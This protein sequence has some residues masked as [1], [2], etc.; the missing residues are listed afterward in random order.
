MQA[1][2]LFRGSGIGKQLFITTM[3]KGYE[4]GCKVALFFVLQWN[5]A[6]NFYKKLGAINVSEKDNFHIFEL[7]SD[8]F[9]KLCF[10]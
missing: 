6:V 7:E 9:N 3:K 2:F 8:N 1:H 10:E 4:L 5:P